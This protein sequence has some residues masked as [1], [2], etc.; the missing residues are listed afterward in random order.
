[1]SSGQRISSS[2]SARS[3]ASCCL[4]GAAATADPA[5]V[6]AA[7][8]LALWTAAGR[9][10]GSRGVVAVGCCCQLFL[11]LLPLSSAAACRRGAR[12]ASLCSALL[13]SAAFS[14]G[15]DGP[16]RAAAPRRDAHAAALECAARRHAQR[17][18]SE[19]DT[20]A[21]SSSDTAEDGGAE[22]AQ[23]RSA[24]ARSRLC[25]ATGARSAAHRTMQRD[26]TKRGHSQQLIDGRRQAA[27]AA[28]RA[29]SSLPFRR[30]RN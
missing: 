17:A 27:G 4:L 18:T 13:C 15:P 24:A 9:G 23:A 8:L 20:C 7:L 16:K 11:S 12:I 29:P 14:D 25:A 5:D 26:R 28:L 30:V 1:M 3:F 22:C 10:D 2:G 21:G 19:H 6:C